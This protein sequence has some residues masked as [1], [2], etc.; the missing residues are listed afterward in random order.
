ML[1]VRTAML[2]KGGLTL[3]EV[4]IALVVV[5][6]VFLALM[7]TALVSIDANMTNNL[8]NEAVSIADMRMN[9]ARSVP[10][11]SLVSDAGSLSGCNCPAGFSP[12][13]DCVRRDLRNIP[14]FNFCTNLT[15]QELGGDANCA[16][17]DSDNKQIIITVGW[18]WRGNPYTHRITTIRKR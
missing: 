6:F 10:F 3:V 11:V 13:G 18:N 7:Q 1:E 4:L 8:R 15:C 14:Q 2:N 12:T 9:N 17:D 16:T 5:L